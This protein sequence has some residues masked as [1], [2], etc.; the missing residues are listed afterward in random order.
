LLL[1]RESLAVEPDSP[2]LLFAQASRRLFVGVR[3]GYRDNYVF[4]VS[5]LGDAGRKSN[6]GATAD[7]IDFQ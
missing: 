1:A 4:H 2:E 3:S 7:E 5:L 6:P